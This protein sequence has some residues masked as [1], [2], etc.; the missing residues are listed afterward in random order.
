MAI[1]RYRVEIGYALGEPGGQWFTHQLVVAVSDYDES[2]KKLEEHLMRVGHERFLE[3]CE[4]AR[5][6]LAYSWLHSYQD[7]AED[8][9][10]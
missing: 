10:I 6:N 9:E 4:D 2:F 7:L 8:E 5:F 1:V 3:E